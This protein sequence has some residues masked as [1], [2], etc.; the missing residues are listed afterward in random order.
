MN[1]QKGDPPKG[2]PMKRKLRDGETLLSIVKQDV[3]YS[4]RIEDGVNETTWLATGVRE[5]SE[6]AAKQIERYLIKARDRRLGLEPKFTEP[7]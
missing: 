1:H 3:G 7:K 6:T 4:V 5:L 2:K